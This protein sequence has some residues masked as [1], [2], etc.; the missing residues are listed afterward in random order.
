MPVY[1]TG[2]SCSLRLH[3]WHLAIRRCNAQTATQ[4]NVALDGYVSGCG[5]LLSSSRLKQPF[6]RSRANWTEY[7]SPVHHDSAA[8][9]LGHHVH[10]L[11]VTQV[12]L[13]PVI[14]SNCC[15]HSS[16]RQ[17]Q[18]SGGIPYLHS[19]R[20]WTVSVLYKTDLERPLDARYSWCLHHGKKYKKNH[21]IVSDHRVGLSR[22]T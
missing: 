4:E 3:V 21:A 15:Y 10:L 2:M 5:L 18:Y 8:V 19:I 17:H 11:L 13:D 7:D 22:T 1:G 12:N 16:I 14:R 6:P 9:G 20:F